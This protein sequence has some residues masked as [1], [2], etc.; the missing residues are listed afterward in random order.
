MPMSCYYLIQCQTRKYEF[1]TE[2]SAQELKYWKLPW[3]WYIVGLPSF[4]GAV[5]EH[6]LMGEKTFIVSLA[7]F[8]ASS[9]LWGTL[10]AKNEISNQPRVALVGTS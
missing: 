9:E 1:L 3:T 8:N 4:L 2:D 10:C 7:N 5:A 6:K